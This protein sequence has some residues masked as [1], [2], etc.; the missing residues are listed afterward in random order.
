[1]SRAS[2]AIRAL[3]L[4]M[5]F[6][7]LVSIFVLVAIASAVY[8]HQQTYRDA[9][10]AA[11]K[12]ARAASRI[13]ARDLGQQVGTLTT[14][15]R[16]LA[17]TP[18]LEKTFAAPQECRLQASGGHIDIVAPTGLTACS[19]LPIKGKRDYS[20]AG[21]FQRGLKGDVLEAPVR[22]PATGHWAVVA[23]SPI[24]H[25]RGVAVGLFDLEPVGI[26]LAKKYSGGEP[27]LFV[28]SNRKQILA[29]SRTPRAY[30]GKPVTN[31]DPPRDLFTAED[32]DGVERFFAPTR[33]PGT[34]W[35]LVAGEETSAA[36]APGRA[37]ER[38]QFSILIVGLLLMLLATIATY[39]VLISPIRNMRRALRHDQAVSTQGPA[40]LGKLAGEINALL[41]RQERERQAQK[42]EAVGRLASGIAHD[43]NNLLVIISGGARLL[44]RRGRLDDR[45]TESA[46]RI[47]RAAHR[48]QQLTTQLLAF[49]R[50]R[51]LNPVPTDVNVTVREM[52][53]MLDRVL[54]AK[55]Q[56]VIELEPE[57]P[58]V[59][60][61]EGQ[62]AQVVLNLAINARDAMPE[63]GK[64]T[65]STSEL[66]LDDDDDVAPGQY[67]RIQVADTGSGMDEA[68][69]ARVFD[70]FFT[71]KEEGTGLGLATVHGIVTGAGG[72]IDVTSARN[73]G[74]TF[75]IYLP[76]AALGESLILLETQEATP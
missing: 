16:T 11:H 69:L 21:W 20:H 36:T 22:D 63:G 39:S 66:S 41:H 67:V 68:T 57:L 42:M 37:L 75:S 74:T 58:T 76:N 31:L 55:V 10:R 47:D 53:V 19:S 70:P 6:L 56:T 15:I 7:V 50:Q 9:E 14:Q 34:D 72:L 38:R 8:I 44:Q 29:R 46:E 12:H 32:L 52:T 30:I 71:T 27:F 2:R 5:H 35:R 26:E 65:I 23:A 25:G 13:A 60:I 33:V 17:G 18:G 3:P 51:A 62:L 73:R 59:L 24:P 45:D 4:W 54:G 1:M 49:A 28:I 61:D 40:E 43:F 64:I 48:G